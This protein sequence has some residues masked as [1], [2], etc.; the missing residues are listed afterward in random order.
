MLTQ[1]KR[2]RDKL[3]IENVTFREMDMES[4]DYRDKHFDVAVSAFSIFFVE[5]MKKQL[6]HIA[7]KVKD[8]GVILITTFSDNSFAPLV[9]LFFSDK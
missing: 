8:S 2:N 4:I 5:D 6:I 7:K 9:N 1:A 3:G